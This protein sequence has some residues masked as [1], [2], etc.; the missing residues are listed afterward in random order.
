MSLP[1]YLV[2]ANDTLYFPAGL[3]YIKLIIDDES[4]KYNALSFNFGKKKIIFR[5]AHETPKKSV[6]S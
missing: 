6:N 5:S 1:N 3:I 4:K 2:N